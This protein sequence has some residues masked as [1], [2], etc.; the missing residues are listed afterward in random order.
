M[1]EDPIGFLGGSINLYRYADNQPNNSTDPDGLDTIV[2][3]FWNNADHTGFIGEHSAVFVTNDGH[4][5][6]YDPSGDS[7]INGYHPT[8]DIFLDEDADLE[9]YLHAHGSQN[10][11]TYPEVF[12]FDTTPEQEK[13][14]AERIKNLGHLGSFN[15]ADA[16][17][18]VLKGIGPFK[19][20]GH[21]YK[22]A[23]L[24]KELRELELPVIPRI[25]LRRLK[26][27]LSPPQ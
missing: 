14:I 3:V 2:M 1:T 16:V 13:E 11:D 18:S 15:C 10:P 22:P 26:P 19:D 27:N 4:P 5:V 12:D 9:Q 7:R 6:L 21:N 8:N 20:L 23:A 17:S 25:A 24:A